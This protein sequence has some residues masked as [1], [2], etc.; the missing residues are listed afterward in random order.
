MKKVVFCIQ[1]QQIE[2]IL[3]KNKIINQKSILIRNK[4]D[5]TID[6]LDKH[7]PDYV[8]F[9]HWS[10]KVP[11]EIINAYKC[12]CFHSSPLP[13]GRGGSPLQ[14]MIKRGHQTTEVCS[15]LMEEQFDTGPI[16][17]RSE[18]SLKGS[19]HEILERVYEAVSDQMEFLIRQDIIP[20]KQKGEP[21]IFKRLG[22][23]DNLIDFKISIEEIHDQ[24]RMLDSKLYPKSFFEI[25]NYVIEFSNSSL[26]GNEISCRV[27]IK[28]K[29]HKKA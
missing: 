5:L 17:L 15:L 9:P 6:F 10:Y 21:T 25:D 18:V 27:K 22:P 23:S 20:K 13:Y 19:L 4:G 2:E 26:E 3:L 7:K 14:N 8:M 24:I 29:E 11:L 16:F 28:E 1:N 12:I